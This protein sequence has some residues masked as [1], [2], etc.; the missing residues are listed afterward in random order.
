MLLHVAIERRLSASVADVCVFCFFI[1]CLG[2]SA[3]CFDVLLREDFCFLM[4]VAAGV[5]RLLFMWQLRGVVCHVWSFLL[6]AART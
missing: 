5:V 3:M 2:C 1:A 6:L 4:R